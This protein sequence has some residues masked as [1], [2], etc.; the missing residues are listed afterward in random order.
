MSDN[1]WARHIELKSLLSR[2]QFL[3]LFF[4]HYATTLYLAIVL[5]TG[6]ASLALSKASGRSSDRLCW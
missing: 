1:A 2:G 5:A 6:V 3:A 4:G